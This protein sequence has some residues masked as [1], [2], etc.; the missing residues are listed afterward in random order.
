MTQDC[1]ILY[2]YTMKLKVFPTPNNTE[3]NQEIGTHDFHMIH[4][5]TVIVCSMF[6]HLV[7][8][9]FSLFL[10]LALSQSVFFSVFLCF[11]LSCLLLPVLSTLEI[12]KRCYINTNKMSVSFPA[13][14]CLS[15]SPFLSLS[16][17]CASWAYD[18]KT[19]A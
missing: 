4:I 19:Q 16:W 7:F 2:I 14:L 15:V 3:K 18:L 12:P 5:Y 17:S 6:S 10:F 8:L 11:Y 13:I 9:L 1:V